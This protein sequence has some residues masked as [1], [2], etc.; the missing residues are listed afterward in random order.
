LSALSRKAA[1]DVGHAFVRQHDQAR[2]VVLKVPELAPVLKQIAERP[3][4]MSHDR[5]WADNR[6]LHSISSAQQIRLSLDPTG[7]YH[8]RPFKAN[9]NSR[10]NYS[11]SDRAQFGCLGLGRISERLAGGTN[12][13]LI[14]SEHE[15]HDDDGE[16]G[17]HSKPGPKG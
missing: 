7:C 12:R 3:G 16:Q 9:H 4:M 5:R 13:N 1:A 14:E 11:F 10:V 15:G 2:Q 8:L 6:Q 17:T